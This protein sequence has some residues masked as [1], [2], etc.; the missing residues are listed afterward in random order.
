ME[1]LRSRN[2]DIVAGLMDGVASPISLDRLISQLTG[3][4][5]TAMAHLHGGVWHV[6]VDH[7]V[8]FVLIRPV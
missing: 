2:D 8:P 4:L 3:D 7:Q 6:V 1:K 5:A